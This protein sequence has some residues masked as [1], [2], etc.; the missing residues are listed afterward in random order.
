MYTNLKTCKSWLWDDDGF[1]I[2][3]FN[4][5]THRK[6]KVVGVSPSI[7]GTTFFKK[8]KIFPIFILIFQ[9]LFVYLNKGRLVK[10]NTGWRLQHFVFGPK[11]HYHIK[12]ARSIR[13][14]P[15]QQCRESHS[16]LTPTCIYDTNFF[17]ILILKFLP[18]PIADL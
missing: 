5:S 6:I 11:G 8:F 15:K 10:S 2:F 1:F 18:L 14:E 16:L 3:V 13:Y 4:T 17:I 12:I 7:G 9:N